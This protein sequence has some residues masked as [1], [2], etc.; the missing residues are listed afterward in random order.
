MDRITHTQICIQS[1]V[2]RPNTAQYADT[3]WICI[4]GVSVAYPCP[5]RIRY[6]IRVFQQLSVQRAV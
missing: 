6:A 2:S 3:D 5:I 1:R 4:E